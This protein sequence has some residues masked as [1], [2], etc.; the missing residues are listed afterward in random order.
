MNKQPKLDLLKNHSSVSNLKDN[1]IDEKVISVMQLNYAE[2][3][4]DLTNLNEEEKQL[5]QSKAHHLVENIADSLGAQGLLQNMLVTQLLGTHELQQKL[6]RYATRSLH[7]PEYGQYYVNAVS[8]L[9]NL[10]IQQVNSLQKL[11]GNCQQKVVVE[12]LHVS[13]GGN[14]IIG[15]V[16]AHS[17]Q[18]GG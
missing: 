7:D 13:D 17:M 4:I 1:S 18:E 11:Q 9:S 6:P 8:K 3:Q 14:A 15:H 5:K 10:F 12:H 16:N 2:T